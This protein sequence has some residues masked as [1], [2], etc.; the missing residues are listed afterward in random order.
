[1]AINMEE[2]ELGTLAYMYYKNPHEVNMYN[3]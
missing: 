2:N 3:V 1:M